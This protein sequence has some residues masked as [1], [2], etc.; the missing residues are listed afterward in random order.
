[1]ARVNLLYD[2]TKGDLRHEEEWEAVLFPISGQQADMDQAIAVDYDA[3]DLRDEPPEGARYVLSD[4]KIGTKT[5]FTNA[6]RDLK[7]RLYRG[8]TLELFQNAPLKAF[9]R[10]GESAEDFETRCKRLAEDAADADADK[11]RIALDKKIDRVKEAISKADDR[12][13]EADG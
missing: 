11:L 4:A 1:M 13:R 3:R 9:S 5:F 6:Q 12:V 8:E 2:E 10:P 7:D